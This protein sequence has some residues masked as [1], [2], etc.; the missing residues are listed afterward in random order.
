VTLKWSGA[1]NP[2]WVVKQG[3]LLEIK[4]DKQAIG[5]IENPRPY[6]T[7]T[8]DLNRSDMIYLFTDGYADQFGGP[9]G[10]KLKYTQLNNLVL[11]IYHLPLSE[12]KKKLDDAFQEWK[13]TL[14]QVDDVCI[15]GIKV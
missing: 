3:Q 1:N 11:S 10:K 6:T 12:Q 7:H 5:K 9:M 8:L 14:E 2:L 4:P 15:I 13:G